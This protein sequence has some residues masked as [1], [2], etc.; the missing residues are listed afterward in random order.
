MYD[1]IK[2]ESS[3]AEDITG[4]SNERNKAMQTFNDDIYTILFQINEEHIMNLTK[5]NTEVV[6][7]AMPHEMLE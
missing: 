6:Y 5:H 7:Y 2:I 1:F 3:I 4:T